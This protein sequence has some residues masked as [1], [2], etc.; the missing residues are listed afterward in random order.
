MIP[1]SFTSPRR[2]PPGSGFS[3]VEL[4][5]A[6]AIGLVFI[7]TLTA[8]L[9]NSSRTRTELELASRQIENG[10]YAIQLLSEELSHAGFFGEAGFG[11]TG[12]IRDACTNTDPEDDCDAP[13]PPQH[14]P[15]DIEDLV[16]N[17]NTGKN[18]LGFPLV[19]EHRVTTAPT[20]GN[21]LTT[22]LD[23]LAR[24]T[25]QLPNDT[26]VIRRASTA[27]A[28]KEGPGTGPPWCD[29]IW[30][31]DTPYLQLN[32][33]NNPTSTNPLNAGDVLV[34]SIEDLAATPDE[35]FAQNRDCSSAAPAYQLF[36]RLYYIAAN[37]RPDDGIP[38]L[39]RVELEPGPGPDEYL[40]TPLVEG[41]E[42]LHFEY[43]TGDG[44]GFRSANHTTLNGTPPASNKW[45]QVL[46]VR[47]HLIAR[48]T[49]QTPG[50][51]DIKT[52]Q[53]AGE[54][55]GGTATGAIAIDTR[56]RRQ[57]FT[58]TVRLANMAGNR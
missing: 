4:M 39:A 21:P 14:C 48:D 29:E 33:C 13:S 30:K 19:G 56:F 12:R 17:F 53:F 23:F 22:N 46:A 26:L 54:T 2:A 43:D 34:A 11:A 20:C 18:Y 36:N 58:A 24:G 5:V 44:N 57:V 15:D 31:E 42:Y 51:R 7:L 16:N 9:S 35:L 8:V 47:I 1:N 55:L 28:C 37:N 52:Y 10:R 3:L 27:A 41:I 49:R 50:Y 6:M 38:T 32:A 25:G 40:V 45:P